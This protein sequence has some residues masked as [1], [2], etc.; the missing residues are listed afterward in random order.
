MN[1]AVTTAE[2]PPLLRATKP[3]RE[4]R[5]ASAP[6]T[7]GALSTVGALAP[8]P[9]FRFRPDLS[10]G[11]RAESMVLRSENSAALAALSDPMRDKIRCVYLDPPY[12]NQEVY[13]HYRDDHSHE[14]WL[15][16]LLARLSALRPLLAPNGS[17]WISID[18]RGMHYLKVGADKIFG[19]DNFISTVVWQQRTTRENR[20]VFSNNHEY[21][22]VYAADAGRFKKSRNLLP[23][24][25]ALLSRYKNPDKDSRGPW[26]SVSANVQDG[27]ATASQFYEFVAPSGKRHRPPEGRCW[28]YTWE[29]MQAEIKAGNIWFGKTGNGVPRIKRFLQDSKAGL[30]PETL[31]RADEVG[32]ND[33]AKKHL[34][35]MFPDQ[36][37]FDT[38]KPESLLARILHIATDPGDWVLDPYLGSG[39]TA[40]VAHK[41]GRRYIGIEQG[42]HAV[43]YC[44]RRLQKVVGGEAGGVSSQLGWTGGGGFG[45][46]ERKHEA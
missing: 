44:A 3:L 45:F 40:A 30:T 35:Q 6:A 25:E 20:K 24:T 32:T 21:L 42:E 23:A 14:E 9:E 27:H 39:T 1:N 4:Q 17:V 22:L 29:R 7:I 31:W 38:P 36:P 11:E 16:T 34:L 2:H 13:R 19:R 15:E 41:M 28:V 18:D 8:S 26:Q 43:T 37:V 5:A 46:Y 33:D 10:V 12:N